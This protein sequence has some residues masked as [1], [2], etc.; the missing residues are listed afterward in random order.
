MRIIVIR[1]EKVDMSWDRKYNSSAY[2]VACERYDLIIC[3]WLD[4]K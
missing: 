1:H 4:L 3:G 2:D